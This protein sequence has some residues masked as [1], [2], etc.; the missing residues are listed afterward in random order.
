MMNPIRRMEIRVHAARTL[1]TLLVACTFS[2]CR[3]TT[4][5]APQPAHVIAVPKSITMPQKDSV[6][7]AVSVTDKDD[8][9][10][11]GAAVTFASSDLIIVTV[12]NLGV[13]NSVGPAGTTSVVAK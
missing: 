11:T 9:L 8:Q 3:S 4:E 12:T 5:G 1:P 10:I 6:S 7:V 13:V 2:A